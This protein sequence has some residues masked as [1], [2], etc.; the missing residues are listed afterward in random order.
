MHWEKGSTG[1]PEPCCRRAFLCAEIRSGERFL[2]MMAMKV[3][4]PPKN[5]FLNGEQK[6]FKPPNEG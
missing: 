2:S 4:F 5:S 1:L 3:V 6:R